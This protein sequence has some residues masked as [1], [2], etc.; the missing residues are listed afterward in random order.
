METPVE[1]FQQRRHGFIQHVL[2]PVA[3]TIPAEH[4]QGTLPALLPL[5]GALRYPVA[6]GIRPVSA[7]GPLAD[8]LSTEV[9]A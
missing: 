9:L 1:I 7:S 8:A 3:A 5:S 2:L 6:S 4:A